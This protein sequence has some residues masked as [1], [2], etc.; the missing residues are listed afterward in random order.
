MSTIEFFDF[1]DTLQMIVSAENIVTR[2]FYEGTDYSA[3]FGGWVL[4]GATPLC[5]RY[6]CVYN[7]NLRDFEETKSFLCEQGINYKALVD[8]VVVSM[9]RDDMIMLFRID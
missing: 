8:D 9:E 1:L 2:R 5:G 3:A 6:L 4:R 7:Y